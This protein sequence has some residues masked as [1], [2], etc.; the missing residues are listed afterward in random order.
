MDRVEQGRVSRGRYEHLIAEV[1][2][3]IIK[4]PVGEG[5]T[6]EQGGSLVQSGKCLKHKGIRGRRGFDVTGKREVKRV[7]DHGIRKDRSISIVSSGIEVIPPGESISRS[8]VSPWGNLP[9]KIKVLKKERPVG[10]SSGEFA[11]VF[12]IREVPVIGEDGDGVRS[13]LQVLF[14]FHKSKDNG[15]EFSIVNVVVAFG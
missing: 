6:S 8:H 15:E 10:L 4:G 12:E 1:K 7:D 3:S 14:P 2:M 13:P 11:R 9:D 5:G